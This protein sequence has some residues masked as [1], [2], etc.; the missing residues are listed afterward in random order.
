MT[1]FENFEQECDEI[2]A[3]LENWEQ[4]PKTHRFVKKVRNMAKRYIP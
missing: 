4:N 1:T 2:D 3:V